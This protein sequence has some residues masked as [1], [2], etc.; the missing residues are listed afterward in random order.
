[1]ERVKLKEIIRMV[2]SLIAWWNDELLTEVRKT[3]MRTG[4]EGSLRIQ[5]GAY[6]V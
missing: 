5:F 4:L 1:M 6:L 3:G 2:L